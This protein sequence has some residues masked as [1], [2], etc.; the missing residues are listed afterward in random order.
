MAKVDF[1]VVGDD[2]EVLR[3]AETIC[4]EFS[5][6]YAN[7]P[8]LD[9]L[10][11]NE[12][13]Y[14]EATFVLISVE[15]IEDGNELAGYVQVVRQVAPESYIVIS[16]G[17][18]LDPKVSVFI[19]KSGVDLVLIASEVKQT[20]KL[21]FI[22]SQKIKAS[23]MPVK[24]T[25]LIEDSVIDCPLFH[26]LPLNQK[27]IPV[28]R[29]GDPIT[30]DRLG[31]LKEIGEVYV[32]REDVEKYQEYAVKYDNKSK[33]SMA[34]KCRAQFLSLLKSYVDLIL[35]VS[36]QS[37]R[38][39]YPQG[40]ALYAK[41]EQLSR[42]LLT[43]L[44]A[45]GEAWEIINNSAIGEF[46]SVE[47]SP[48][49]A[50][51]AGLLSLEC[52]IGD[53]TAVMTAALIADIGMMDLRPEITKKIRQGGGLSSLTEDEQRDYKAHPITSLHQALSRRLQIPEKTKNM[54]LCSHERMDMKGF[55]NCP[56]GD[57]IPYEAMLIQIC[58]MIDR[59]SLIR[60]GEK[61][62]DIRDVKKQIY[63]E[64]SRTGSV[65]SAQML[66]KVRPYL[67]SSGRPNAASS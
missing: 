18:K 47:R 55:P 33:H 50:A 6:A 34:R 44:G 40:A 25:E 45:V 20:S 41:C 30:A 23:Y 31:K 9:V 52:Q 15:N 1:L 59:S 43:T 60:M 5:Y 58:E 63:L 27:F 12:K 65:F 13:D 57:K 35:L 8:N 61:R 48:A 3:R 67:L 32:R 7:V 66:G 21:E 4:T 64:E 42:E 36:D 26:L 29:P 51:Y 49:I 38:A 19:K 46:G 17:A 14:H 37:E 16:I 24:I 11:D 53:P 22:A 39:S 28:I 62:P 2:Q 10:M 54:I 56:V